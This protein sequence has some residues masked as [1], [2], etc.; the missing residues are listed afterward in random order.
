MREPARA[1][2]ASS[3]YR[4]LIL[5]EIARI[6]RGVYRDQ[7]LTT[8]TVILCGADDPVMRPEFLGGYEDNADD[9][10][11]EV[12]PDASHFIPDEQPDAVVAHALELDRRTVSPCSEPMT[13]SLAGRLRGAEGAHFDSRHRSGF[14][15]AE[16]R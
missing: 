13:G 3:L 1:R 2:A 15:I 14:A 7:K 4:G 6:A 12:V 10:T 16:S 11:I 5:P 8:P 9:L